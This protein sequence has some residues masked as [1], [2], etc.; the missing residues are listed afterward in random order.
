[1]LRLL[2]IFG[3]MSVGISLT[4]GAPDATTI[5]DSGSTNR[6]GF[7]IVIEPSGVAEFTSVSRR[8]GAEQT[9]PARKMLPDTL[10]ERFQTDLRAAKPLDSLPAVHC[11]KS[12]SF[13]SRLTIASGG[14]ETPDLRCGDG[15]NAAMRNLVRDTNEIVAL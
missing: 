6:P 4:P 15:G 2:A 5:I 12:A 13:G 9:K 11:M 14:E 1:M 7:R 3:L 8:A 10:V